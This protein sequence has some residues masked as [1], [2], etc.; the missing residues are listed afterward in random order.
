M[1]NT[2]DIAIVEESVQ[3]AAT[4]ILHH[5]QLKNQQAD[6]KADTASVN[7]SDA[8]TPY[9]YNLLLDGYMS[10]VLVTETAA[11]HLYLEGTFAADLELWQST[12]HFLDRLKH[13]I[14]DE[15]EKEQV[16]KILSG[17]RNALSHASADYSYSTRHPV[18]NAPMFILYEKPK[19]TSNDKGN[20]QKNPGADPGVAHY[21]EV[22]RYT[23]EQFAKLC[24]IM[25]EVFLSWN[26]VCLLK[27]ST[28]GARDVQMAVMARYAIC[29]QSCS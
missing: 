13:A 24:D 25:R 26:R 15:N 21:K 6:T 17:I 12:T 18:S 22:Q 10:V 27:E 16:A 5:H 2:D 23:V 29:Q 4:A 7:P 9:E 14:S 8:N 11:K 20:D 1:Q 28:K 3:T 19:S